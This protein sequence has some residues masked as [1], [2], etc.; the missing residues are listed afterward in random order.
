MIRIQS[1]FTLIEIAIVLMVVGLLL[2]GVQ[3]GQQLVNIATEK[4]LTAEFKNIPLYIFSYQDRFNALPGDDLSVVHHFHGVI[5]TTPLG[6]QG[7]GMID[8]DWNSS[9]TTDESYLLWQHVRLAGLASGTIDIAD[10]NYLPRNTIGGLIGIQSGTASAAH[11]PIDAGPGLTHPIQGSYIVCSS[12]IPGKYVKHLD[13][14]LDDGDTANG[15][16][17]A[18]PTAGYETGAAIATPT[19][20]IEDG[21]PYTVCLGV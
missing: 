19:A 14:R 1:G 8:G 17:L 6:A 15:S 2:G 21:L 5:S 16:M 4:N 18:T 12:G 9:I 7:N 10:A 3:K 13:A 11:S 20:L